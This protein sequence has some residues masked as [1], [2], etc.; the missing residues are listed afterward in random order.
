MFVNCVQYCIFN[1][2]FLNCFD[3][4]LSEFLQAFIKLSVIAVSCFFYYFLSFQ[5]IRNP[6]I[7][8]LTHG[9]IFCFF[10]PILCNNIFDLCFRISFLH[11]SAFFFIRQICS[12]LPVLSLPYF[13]GMFFQQF[14]PFKHF[15]LHILYIQHIMFNR[16]LQ[17]CVYIIKGVFLSLT[18]QI[19]S[20]LFFIITILLHPQAHLQASVYFFHIFRSDLT[21]IILKTTFINRPYLF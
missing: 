11:T 9:R 15:Y 8:E 6:F 3:S 4:S 19:V 12:P 14:L 1:I 18:F 17:N 13:I 20:P 16:I 10:F 21:D 5:F 2:K 7:I